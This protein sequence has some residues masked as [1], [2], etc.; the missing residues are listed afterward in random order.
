MQLNDLGSFLERQVDAVK[1]DASKRVVS[2]TLGMVK[3]LTLTTP[4]DTSQALSNWQVSVGEPPIPVVLGPAAPGSH[5]S[6]QMLSA[7]ATQMLASV[8]LTG[9]KFGKTVYLYNNAD[10]IMKLERGKSKQNSAFIATAVA[11]GRAKIKV[12]K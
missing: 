7:L 11:N 6:T 9:R 8:I 4:V 3:E 10:Y 1:E 2:T 5:G 12:K